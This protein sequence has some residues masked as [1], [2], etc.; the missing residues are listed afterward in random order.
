L[1]LENPPVPPE[2]DATVASWMRK[3]G[4]R[5]MSARVEMDP[6]VNFYVWEEETPS[7]GRT[8]ALWIEDAMVRRL[9][10]EQLV[11]VL[12]Q[13]EVAEDIRINFK[14]RIEERGAEYRV[15]V[16]PRR[17]GEFRREG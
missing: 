17:S 2:T 10:P 15:S 1:T 3:H 4:W 7:I 12:N 6:E 16:V 11:K 5:V 8:H 9:T 13:E 14:V